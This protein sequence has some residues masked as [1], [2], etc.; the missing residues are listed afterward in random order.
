[1]ALNVSFGYSSLAKEAKVVTPNLV[2]T[3]SI[4]TIVIL[5]QIKGLQ[6]VFLCLL[7]MIVPVVTFTE[8]TQVR[9]I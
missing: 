9:Y 4:K 5:L 6:F 2:N 7:N 3:N 1:M 8:I